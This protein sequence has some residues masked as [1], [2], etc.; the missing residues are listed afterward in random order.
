M[1]LPRNLPSHTML[2]TLPQL[3]SPEDLASA[4]ATL[5]QAP[6]ADG[7]DSAGPQARAVKNNQQ[8]PHDS[9]AAV[10]IRRL[11][12][13]RLNQSARFFSATLPLRIFTPRINRY[14]GPNNAYGNHI[15][16]AIRLQTAEHG[17]LEHVRSDVSCTVF[18][19]EPEAY[20]GGELSVSD[21]FGPRRVKLPAGHAVLYPGTSLHQVMPVT[22][23]ERLACF[24]WVQSMVRSDEQRRLL[25]E[26]DM[27]LLALRSQHGETPETTALTG[28]YHNLLRMWAET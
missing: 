27:N 21:T 3:L 28:T 9:E 13:E 5:A 23:G 10:A 26:L 11:V 25:Y 6:W 12:L 18:L 19:N 8:L 20:E 1:A 2:I 17:G 4:H 22:R 14:S 7:A 24:F 16:N 15:D